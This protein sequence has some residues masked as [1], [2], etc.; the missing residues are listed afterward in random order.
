M[1][2]NTFLVDSLSV[3]K[4][5]Y[6]KSDVFRGPLTVGATPFYAKAY[7]YDHLSQANN[8]LCNNISIKGL[9]VYSTAID[10]YDI[11]S[12]YGV[13]NNVMAVKWNLPTGQRSYLDTIERVFNYRV[14]GRKSEL[15]NLNLYNAGVT[16]NTLKTDLEAIV[17]DNIE[18]IAPAY[19][20][21]RNIKWNGE[22]RSAIASSAGSTVTNVAEPNFAGNVNLTGQRRGVYY[23]D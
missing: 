23:Y 16:D 8:H 7:L 19:T 10:F 9:T 13:Y 5:A 22:T 14:P 3:P 2:I 18:S 4:G 20:K 17:K 6:S 12:H 11:K 15:Y 21:L 1:Y